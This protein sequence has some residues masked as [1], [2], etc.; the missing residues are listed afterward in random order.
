MPTTRPRVVVTETDELAQA[1]DEAARRWPGES[2]SAL[3]L[4]LAI[5]ATRAWHAER[6]RE[7]QGRVAAIER[8]AGAFSDGYDPTLLIELREDWPE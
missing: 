6:E 4:R 2:R 8:W 3:L 5:E 1:L 7:A